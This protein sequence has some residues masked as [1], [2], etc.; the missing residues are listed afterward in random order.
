MM[1]ESQQDDLRRSRIEYKYF[2]PV[3]ECLA[4]M[5]DLRVFC[6]EDPNSI[7]GMGGYEVASIYC[8]TYDLM[9]YYD[10]MAGISDRVK[11]RFRFYPRS[12]TD[13]V[14]CE[15]KQK[16]ADRVL[17]K[18]FRMALSDFHQLMKGDVRGIPLT[19][20]GGMDYL[21]RLFK[22]SGFRP[23]IRID[24]Q[25]AAFFARNDPRVRVTMDRRVKCCRPVRYGTNSPSIPVFPASLQ[26][27]EVKTPGYFPAWLSRIVRKR[28]L[29]REAIS[30]YG[31][32]FDAIGV[33][34]GLNIN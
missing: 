26:I 7:V 8:D 21:F 27:L 25:R 30:K 31:A 12:R 20:D 3:T 24:Y 34:Y 1:P 18:T 15:L 11:L 16:R 4:L 32:A 9:C 13:W 28:D 10:K 6:H 33:N 22:V 2:V 29:H 19:D 5:T 23:V 14:A 17:K